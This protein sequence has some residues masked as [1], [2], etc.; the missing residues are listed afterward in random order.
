MLRFDR[1]PS[2]ALGWGI[3]AGLAVVFLID[4]VTAL[5]FAEWVL[6]LLPVFATVFLWRT[7]QVCMVAA[8]AG[9]LTSVGFFTS[10]DGIDPVMAVANRS[11]GLLTILIVAC[12]CYRSVRQKLVERKQEWL[13]HGQVHLNELMAGEQTVESLGQNVLR[14]FSEYLNSSSG[15]MYVVDGAALRLAASYAIPPGCK[16]PH[17]LLPGQGLVGQALLDRR[18]FR[19]EQVA[20]D[21]LRIGSALG[22]MVPRDCL[23]CPVS[24]HGMVLGVLELGFAGPTFATDMELIEQVSPAIGVAIKACNYLK[25]QV[26]LLEETTRQGEELQSQAEELRVSNEELEEQSRALRESQARLELQQTE[27]EQINTQ[28]EEQASTLEAQTHDLARG[29]ALLEAQ[30][31]ELERSSRYKSEFLANMSHELRTPLN[32][33]L[34]LSK[35]LAD[36]KA[37]NLTPE[38]VKYANTIYDAGNDLLNLINDILDLAKIE[39]GRL[40]IR[41]ESVSLASLVDGLKQMFEPIA[42]QKQLKLVMTIETK[43]KHIQSDASR[44]DQILKNLLANACKFTTQGEVSLAIRDTLEGNIAFVVQDTGI[45][46]PPEQHGVIFEAFRQADGTTNRKFGGTG[47]GLSISRELARLLGGAITLV[48][49]AGQ[50]SQFTLTIPRTAP[51]QAEA[52]GLTGSLTPLSFEFLTDAHSVPMQLGAS[53]SVPVRIPV[54][55]TAPSLLSTDNSNQRLTATE[56]TQLSDDRENSKADQRTILIVEDDSS[57]AEILMELSRERHFNCL[58][59][60]SADEGL[61]LATEYL[62]SAIVLDIGLPDQSGLSV[63]DRLKHDVRTRHI[64]VHIVSAS[65]YTETALSLGAVGYMLKPVKRE[66]LAQTLEDLQLRLTQSMRRVLVV[67][68]DEVQLDSLKSLLGTAEVEVIGVR[69]AG[70]CLEK[71]KATTFDCMVLDLSLPDATGFSLLETLSREDRYAFPPVIVYTGRDLS[72]EE[73]QRLRRYSQSIIIKGAR[74]PERL[75]DEVTL[76]LHQV[77]QELSPTQQEMLR[78]AQDR[79]N[80]LTGR[81]VLVVEDDVR[82]VFALTSILEPQGVQVEIARNGREALEVLQ[83]ATTDS[84]DLVLMDLMMPEMDGL[85]AIREIRKNRNWARIP[86]IAL[87]AKAMKNDQQFCLE[88]G[89]NDYMAKPL[90][91]QRLIS[92]V[93]V[94]MPRG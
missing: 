20:H 44:L 35:L 5:G 62:P 41:H 6:Y 71:L 8:A 57:F 53:S 36:N 25:R 17:T 48:S 63:L 74:S 22:Q 61:R 26:E 12:V 58:V 87:T 59:A 90:D 80:T 46:I 29:K 69:T 73:E 86:I 23:V 37:G 60:H 64:P 94:W 56:K 45:G 9:V 72:A 39:S 33:S 1:N 2:P 88:A 43:V 51:L 16:T 85:T 15:V 76:F 49:E 83:K 4:C 7:Y 34:I 42:E 89:A 93:R 38:Q 10:P 19:L 11:L 65:D 78:R 66:Q 54:H 32:S 31:L 52:S 27:L 84:I 75:L 28:L 47:L 30:K 92:L 91:V 81:R 14:F 21:Y 67:E 40:D 50:G 68:D 13:Q 18:S 79:E 82:N 3:G 24:A 70:D 55:S 77:V